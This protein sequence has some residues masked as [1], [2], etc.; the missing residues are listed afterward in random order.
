MKQKFVTFLLGDRLYG[1]DIM[2]VKGIEKVENI[3]IIPNM[4]KSIR[5]VF[6]LRNSIIPIIDLKKRFTF[7]E[8]QTNLDIIILVK[9][10]E[11]ELGIL[12][13]KVKMVFEI[14]ES[15]IQTPPILNSGINRDYLKGITKIDDKDL[16]MIID[17]DKL[18]SKEELLSL[19]SHL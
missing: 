12:I 4:P 11:M 14:E 17:L 8:D 1:L 9:T 15:N 7:E 10:N 18:F 3:Y 2:K 5:G 16:L 6:K 19:K 13:D